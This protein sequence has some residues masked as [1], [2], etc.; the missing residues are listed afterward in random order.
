MGSSPNVSLIDA[1]ILSLAHDRWQKVAMIVARVAEATACDDDSHC[2]AI[3]DRVRAL[4]N[5]GRLEAQGDISRWRHSE[6][7]KKG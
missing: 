3:A 7:R 1:S 5:S 2:D 4:V 6:I